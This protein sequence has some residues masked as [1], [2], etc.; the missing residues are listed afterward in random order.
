M[1]RDK[2]IFPNTELYYKEIRKCEYFICKWF[3]IPISMIYKSQQGGLV[4]IITENNEKIIFKILYKDYKLLK[5][6]L[7]KNGNVEFIEK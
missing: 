2:L 1:E 3:F 5:S 6:N 7:I 4:R